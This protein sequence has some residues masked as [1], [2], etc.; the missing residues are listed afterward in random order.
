MLD[1]WLD[2]IIKW[3]LAEF[4]ETWIYAMAIAFGL[5]IDIGFVLK[6]LGY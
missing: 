4:V 6:Q 1:K 2:E 3:P 5:G